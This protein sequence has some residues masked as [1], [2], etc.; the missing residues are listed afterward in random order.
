MPETDLTSEFD[1]QLATLLAAGYPQLAGLAEADFLVQ[2]EPLR[3]LVPDAADGDRARIPFVLVVSGVRPEQAISVVE[4]R[5]KTGFTSM[6]SD[7]LKRF[8]PIPAVEL[9]D[10]SAYLI[11]DVDTGRATL[12]VTPENGVEMIL[13][14]GRSPLTLDEGL[15]LVTQFPDVLR[16][17]NCFEMTGSRCGDRRVTGLWV[18]KDGRPRLGWCWVGNPHSWLGM[19]SCGGRVGAQADQP[20]G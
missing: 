3:R 11:T 4:L 13:S 14:D 7:E 5:G 20:V 17:M 15:A 9:P 16:S 18:S 6:E 8:S 12:N 19:A 1:R 10:S 2:I